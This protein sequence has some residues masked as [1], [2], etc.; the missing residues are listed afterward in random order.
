MNA[1]RAPALALIA[2]TA[3]LAGPGQAQS[4]ARNGLS[5]APAASGF[6]VFARAG[7]P[8]AAFF[9]AAGDFA[10]RAGAASNRRVM[11]SRPLGPSV[12]RPGQRSVGFVLAP[13]D[14]A[15]VQRGG[16]LLNVRTTGANVSVG[17]AVALCDT[18]AGD[19]AGGQHRP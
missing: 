15:F 9:C 1:L 10:R 3:I 11:V 12:G 18:V 8:G 5:V 4:V 14:G 17:H 6:E 13:P 7:L 16:I 2:C 19:P